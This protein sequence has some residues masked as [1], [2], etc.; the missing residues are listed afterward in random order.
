MERITDSRGVTFTYGFSP[1]GQLKSLRDSHGNA[2]N[3]LY[4]PVGRL[5]GIWAHNYGT[6]SYRYDSGGRLMEKW[7]PNGVSTRYDYHPDDSLRQ[8]VNRSG[9]GLISQHDY[10]YDGFGNRNGHI[11]T[12]GAASKEK[13]VA[14]F[15][16]LRLRQE[17]RQSAHGVCR[18]RFQQGR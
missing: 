3:Y 10:T 16:L 7:L 5:T 1:G 13:S 8:A 14:S 17:P 9:Q 6:V 4:D 15:M 12:V 11:E 2:T 18:C